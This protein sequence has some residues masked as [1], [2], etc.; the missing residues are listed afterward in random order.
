MS[1]NI[2]K[3]IQVTAYLL[4]KYK[5]FSLSYLKLIK[6]LYLADREAIGQTGVS[7]TGDKYYSLDKGPI[8]SALYD[9]IK[10]KYSDA[11]SQ[12]LWNARFMTDGYNLLPVTERIPDS[13]LSEF[14]KETLD[15]VDKEYHN[16][17]WQEM[18]DIVHRICPE[19]QNPKGSRLPITKKAILESLG[20]TE[21]E[22]DFILSEDEFYKNEE[23]IFA[24][25]CK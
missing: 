1:V 8:L 17:T 13:K 3:L 19:W 7:I 10:N 5:G 25:L 2:E 15:K 9:L 12:N 24:S 23:R 6:L 4:K 16:E 18:I 14:E 21:E 20:C 22:I 11:A